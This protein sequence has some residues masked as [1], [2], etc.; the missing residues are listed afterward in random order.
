MRTVIIDSLPPAAARYADDW[1]IVVVDV[2]RFTTT[3]LTAL[4]MGREVY[5]ARTSDEAASIAAQLKD[6]LLVGELGGNVPYGFDLSNSPV[7]VLALQKIPAGYFTAAHRPLVLVSSSGAQ[8]AVNSL[9]A[10]SVYFG[11]LRNLS[12]LTSMLQA[13]HDKVAVLGAGT[14]GAFRREDQLCCAWIAEILIQNG[15]K[16]A[17]AETTDLVDNWHGANIDEIRHGRSAQYLRS[18]GQTHD[19]EFVLHHI[20][21]LSLAP[22]MTSNGALYPD[23][24]PQRALS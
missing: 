9:G 24:N 20:D 19:L 16:A 14:R 18:T 12:A 5:P 15:F 11:C 23:A 13:R 22:A 7:Q 2:I 21:D 3:A 8:L 6:P 10:K 4:A 17:N 1:T